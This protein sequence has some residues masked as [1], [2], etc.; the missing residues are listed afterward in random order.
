MI[1]EG[2]G[3]RYLARGSPEVMRILHVLP[4]GNHG[5][6]QELALALARGAADAGHLVAVASASGPVLDTFSG[7]Y[8]PLPEALNVPTALVSFAV[9][10]GCLIRRWQPDIVHAHSARLAPSAS[11][12]TLAGR[13]RPAVITVHG[14]PP[15]QL[16]RA[17]RALRWSRLPVV[18]VGRGLAH[19][20]EEHTVFCQTIMNGISAAPPAADRCL[21]NREWDIDPKAP[22]IVS[23]GRLVPQK[24]HRLAIQALALL[25]SVTL[26][27]VGEGP[28]RTDLELLTA[29]LGLSGRVRLVGHR[30]DA[31]AIL[32]AGD[33]ALLPS[34]WEGLPRVGLEALAAG[35]PLVATAVVGIA[36]TFDESCAVLVT[37]NDAPALAA[38]VERVLSRPSLVASLVEGGRRLVGELSERRMVERYLDLYW[39]LVGQPL[40]RN[41]GSA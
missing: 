31:R 17:A 34:T 21:L 14:L 12:A 16:A 22:L 4:N 39:A 15:E 8:L 32:G 2:L 7:E 23:V 30:A 27:V 3:A 10:L 9:R 37:P 24:N 38:G 41:W 29:E 25:P 35:V 20:L 19:E 33:V 40:A 28:L 26:V 18:S 5:G 11:L 36:D 13:A 1:S 6:M